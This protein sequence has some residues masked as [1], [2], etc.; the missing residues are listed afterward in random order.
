MGWDI[1]IDAQNGSWAAVSN[2]AFVGNRIGFRFDSNK[3]TFSNPTYENVVFAENE[4]GLQVVNVP[5]NTTLNFFGTVFD[6]NETD[7]DDPKGLVQLS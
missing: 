1:G 6:N 7:V 2:A 5:S 3:S 4:T